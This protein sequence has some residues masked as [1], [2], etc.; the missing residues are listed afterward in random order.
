MSSHAYHPRHH[1]LPNHAVRSRVR[2]LTFAPCCACLSRVDS[3]SIC[4]LLS[5]CVV[6][7]K[8]SGFWSRVAVLDLP[9]RIPKAAATRSGATDDLT[10]LR[11][12]A[13]AS[14]APEFVRPV[15]TDAVVP[16]K[17]VD[18]FSG[19]RRTCAKTNSHVALCGRWCARDTPLVLPLWTV[20]HR[21]S[22]RACTCRIGQH[23]LQG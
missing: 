8:Q 20:T 12:R 7:Y 23:G 5:L 11:P 21:L 10:H 2:S 14:R 16:R 17:A 3:H 9:S 15:A 13:R 18:S 22:S 1:E 19:N 4:I 6:A